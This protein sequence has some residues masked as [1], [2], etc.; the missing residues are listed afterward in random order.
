MI[1]IDD[2]LFKVDI[3]QRQAVKLRYAHSRVEKNIDDLVILAVAVVV[4]YEFQKLPHLLTA[5]CFSCHAVVDHNSR[6]LKPK[7]VLGENIIIYRHLKR[8]AKYASNR[9]DGAVPSPLFL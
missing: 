7:R 1:N 3:M 5:D 4:V 6:K 2:P 9:F 8:G